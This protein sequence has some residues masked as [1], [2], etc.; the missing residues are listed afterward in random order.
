MS[1]DKPQTGCVFCQRG[2]AD[3]SHPSDPLVVYR[4]T[5]AYLVLNKYPYNNGHL[6][7]VP[8]RHTPTLA[9]LTADELQ[10]MAMLT[11]RTELALREAYSPDG[12]NVGINLGKPAGAGVVEHVHIHAVPR[13]NGDTNFMTV[14]GDTRVLPEDLQSTAGRLRPIFARL[15]GSSVA[16]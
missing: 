7:I 15:L 12:I 9:T 5:L 2:Q 4:G 8:Y 11:Q 13:W 3:A 16:G 14:F 10:E 1:G 6:L